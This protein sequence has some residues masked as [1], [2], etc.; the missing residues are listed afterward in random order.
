MFTFQYFSTHGYTTKPMFIFIPKNLIIS[1]LSASF[2]IRYR[3]LCVNSRMDELSL[4][5]KKEFLL[6]SNT[7][8]HL[9]ISYWSL[10]TSSFS[11]TLFTGSS[12]MQIVFFWT[13]FHFLITANKLQIWRLLWTNS[14]LSR[15]SLLCWFHKII[16]Y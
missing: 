9:K 8:C 15:S 14:S 13:S 5:C 16:I 3:K 2:Q 1:S 10:V 4:V 6:L 11:W 12:W 7:F